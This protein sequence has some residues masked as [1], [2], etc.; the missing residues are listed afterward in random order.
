MTGQK[1]KRRRAAAFFLSG[2]LCASSLLARP[3][4]AAGLEADYLVPVG[5]TIGIKLFAEGVVVIGLAEVEAG[6]GGM[7]TPGADCGLRVGD[8]I[9]AVGGTE[10][11]SSEQF[12]ALLQCG[13]M[14][15]L[16]VSRNGEDLTLAAQPVQGSDG[17]WRLGA[18]IRDSMAGIGT[19]TFYDPRT[20]TFGALGHGITDTDTGLLMP[21]GGGSVMHASVKAVKQG[22]AGDP[23]ELKGSFDLTHD[24]GGLHANTE[25]GV[26]GEMAPCGLT[27]GDAVPV[28]KSGEVHIGAASILSNVSGDE[29]ASYSIEIIRVLDTAGVQNL[30]LQVTDP[31]LI[32]QTGGIVQGMSGSPILQDGKLVGA[33]THVMVNEPTKG[34]GILIENMLSDTVPQS[35]AQ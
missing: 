13:G 16:D 19:V 1:G 21:L 10:V 14:V 11:E 20:G 31:A 15:E 34:Y 9:E 29:V 7:S 18:W 4:Q 35:N 8:V 25:R 5:H 32:A 23:G 26:F 17:T 3:A 6:S 33:V 28:A 2:L 30:L 24:L 12:A 27:E 22:S